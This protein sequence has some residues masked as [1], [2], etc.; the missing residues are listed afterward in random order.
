VQGILPNHPSLFDPRRDDA[1]A[2]TSNALRSFLL[3]L[4]E[5]TFHAFLL[6][7]GIFTPHTFL[8]VE[9]D[10]LADLWATATSTGKSLA[11]THVK[12]MK[13]FVEILATQLRKSDERMYATAATIPLPTLPNGQYVPRLFLQSFMDMMREDRFGW[14][15]SAKGLTTLDKFLNADASDVANLWA[16]ETSTDKST[17]LSFVNMMKQRV[18][19]LRPSFMCNSLLE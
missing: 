9:S 16:I 11:L 15:L 19:H 1:I 5:G 3:M 12:R 13:V 6:S 4:N 18:N 8:Q 7:K 17:A 10:V 2:K 14:F